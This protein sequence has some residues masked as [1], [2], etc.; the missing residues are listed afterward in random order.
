[1]P[2]CVCVAKISHKIQLPD[3]HHNQLIPCGVSVVAC[4]LSP[5]CVLDHIYLPPYRLRLLQC[6]IPITKGV[7]Q[8]TNVGGMFEYH[9]RQECVQI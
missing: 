4:S 6:E 8:L 1:M 9:P 7:N 2:I 5:C 3:E